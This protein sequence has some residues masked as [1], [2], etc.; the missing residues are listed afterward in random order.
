MYTTNQSIK[1][2]NITVNRTA[3]HVIAFRLPIHTHYRVVHHFVRSRRTCIQFNVIMEYKLYDYVTYPVVPFIC[4]N[5]ILSYFSH[6][7]RTACSNIPNIRLSLREHV[8]NIFKHNNIIRAWSYYIIAVDTYKKKLD[9][10]R[11]LF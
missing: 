11:C 9:R 2:I 8:K 5:N 10:C 6:H 3:E 4:K 1:T 7:R